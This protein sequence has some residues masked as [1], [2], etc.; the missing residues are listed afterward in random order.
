[1]LKQELN[2]RMRKIIDKQ[3]VVYLM[4]FYVG[5]FLL[6]L[7]SGALGKWK[8]AA[9]TTFTWN[10]FFSVNMVRYSLKLIFIIAAIYFVRYLEVKKGI[11]RWSVFLLHILFGIS[12]TFYSVTS[13]VIVNN[14]LFNTNDPLTFNYVYTGALLGT[15]YNF[16]LYFS[17]AA[18][19]I[20]YYFFQ[21]QKDFQLQENKLKTQLLDSKIN[22]LQSQL[23]PHFL[24]NTL[25]DISSLID[26][27]PEKAQ[28]A[29]SDL[30]DLL[31]ET[32]TLKD[33]KFVTVAEELR[34]LKKYLDIEKLRFADKVEFNVQIPETIFQEK[35][36]PLMLQPF[37]ENAIKHG[38]SLTH[39]TLQINILFEE[40]ETEIHFYISNNGKL[41]KPQHELVYGT[42]LSNVLSRLETIYETNFKFEIK[43]NSENN[44]VTAHIM[45]PKLKQL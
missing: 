1:M 2:N 44:G 36:P 38:F 21:K 11:A 22:A 23:Q 14:W 31:R 45:I 41:L 20:V 40:K 18:I 6:T 16:F 15:D 30:S 32:L 33:V 37:V 27:Q 39:D 9:Y 8:N 42:G 13:Q 3:L 43:N 19:V 29:I 17:M 12:L 25:N 24:F 35:I 10:E 4:A 7:I 26:I 34:L 5:F 28:D